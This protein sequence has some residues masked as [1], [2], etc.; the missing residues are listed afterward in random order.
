MEI[1]FWFFIKNE[2]LVAFESQQISWL[3]SQTLIEYSS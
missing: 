3:I 2:S 1:F